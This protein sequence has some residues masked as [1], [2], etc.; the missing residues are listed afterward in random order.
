MERDHQECA[1]CYSLIVEPVRIKCQHVYC[2][3]CIEKLILDGNLKCPL[4]R[5]EFDYENDLT[6]DDSVLEKNFKENTEEFTEKANKIL[7]SRKEKSKMKEVQILYGNLHELINSS[8]SNTNKWTCYVKINNKQ[9]RIKNVLNKLKSEEKLIKILGRE[10]EK[11][12]E[13]I[14]KYTQNKEFK[15]KDSDLI[16]CVTF[17][18]HPTFNPPSIKVNVAPFQIT[19]IGWGIFNIELKIE[20][21]NYLK[22]ETLRLSHFLSFSNNDTY[23][24]RTIYVDMDKI[25]NENRI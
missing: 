18:L 9:G 14:D 17:N 19:R 21:H 2:L 12:E 5:K 25:T 3:I 8:T 16:K 24:M 22:L 10:N 1:V 23:N 6:Y 15:L 13:I 20:F 7:N 11:K 4:D